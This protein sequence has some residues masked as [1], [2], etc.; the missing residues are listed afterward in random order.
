M[1]EFMFQGQSKVGSVASQPFSDS[2][3]TLTRDVP[4][5]DQPPEENRVQP[6]FNSAWLMRRGLPFVVSGALALLTLWLWQSLVNQDRVRIHRLLEGEMAKVELT[7]QK[8]FSL[9]STALVRMAE[10]R[11]GETELARK[12]WENDATHYLRDFPGHWIIEWIDSAG[13]TRWGKTRDGVSPE[14]LKLAKAALERFKRNM[15]PADE[16]TTGTVVPLQGNGKDFI[17]SVPIEHAGKA[18]GCILGVFHTETL[19]REFIDGLPFNNLGVQFLYQ[20]EAIAT[21]GVPPSQG[22]HTWDVK[23]EVSLNNVSLNAKMYPAARYLANLKSPLPSLA[24]VLGMLMALLVGL[25]IGVAQMARRQQIS[26]HRVNQDLR[27]ENAERTRIQKE[28]LES[29]QRFRF[30]FEESP[31]GM[32]L[33]GQD[34]MVKSAN[35]ALSRLLGYPGSELETLFL[36]DIIDPQDRQRGEEWV[37]RAFKGENVEQGL[38]YRCVTQ[39]GSTV[40]VNLRSSVLTHLEGALPLLLVM[41]EDVTPRKQIEDLQALQTAVL[42]KTIQGR[43]LPEILDALCLQIEQIVGPSVC[44]IMLLDKDGERLN[45]V[46]APSAPESLCGTLNGLVPGE[47]MASCGTA[48]FTGKPVIVTDTGSDPRWEKFRNVAEKFGIKSCWSIPIFSHGHMPLGSFA[49]SHPHPR[50]PTSLDL[51]VLETAS[52]LAGVAIQHQQAAEHLQASEDR[53]RDLFQSAPSAYITTTMEGIILSANTRTSELLGYSQEQ[54]IGSQMMDFYVNGSEGQEKANQVYQFVGTKS[55]MMGQDLKMIG[56]DGSHLWVNLAVQIFYD[57]EGQPIERRE[58]LEDVTGRK[59]AEILLGNQKTILEMI[60]QGKPLTQILTQLCA[61]IESQTPGMWCSV[62][63]LEGQTL[64]SAAAPHLPS[65]FLRKT[66]RVPI[67]P[68]AGS[69][70]TAAYRKERVIVADIETDPL[71]KKGRRLALENGLRACWSTPIKPSDEVLGTFAMY[72]GESRTPTEEETRLIDISTGLAGMAIEQRRAVEALEY[73]KEKYRVLYED[74]PTMYFTVASDGTVLSVNQF[75]ASQLGYTPEELVGETVLKVIYPEDHEKAQAR[76]K[77]IFLHPDEVSHWEFRKIRKDRSLLWVKETARVITRFDGSSVVLIVCED[78]SSQKKVE[79]AL[80]E[81]IELAALDAEISQVVMQREGLPEMLQGCAE[82]LVPSLKAGFGGIWI[83][84]DDDQVLELK[85]S[86]GLVAHPDGPPH[87]VPVGALRL[88]AIA[89][90]RK[91]QVTK[92]IP[93]DPHVLEQEWA[94]QEGLTSFAGYPLIL[95][96]SVIGVLAVYSRQELNVTTLQALG[97]VANRITLGIEKIRAEDAR[98]ESEGRLQAILDNSSA[99]IYLKDLEGRYL[100]INRTYERIFKLD[101]NRVKGKTDK[102]IFPEEI[103]KAF[104]ENDRVALQSGL[105]FEK[106]E[107]APRED[108]L[109][110]Y[111]SN[112]FPLLTADGVPYALCGISTDIT[113]RKQAETAL[114]L[115]EQRLRGL[116][117]ERTKISQDLH[118]HI[119]QSLYAAGLIIAAA[120]QPVKIQDSQGALDYLEQAISQLNVA[121]EEIRIFIEGLPRESVDLGDFST[122]L[123]ALVEALTLPKSTVFA[124]DLDP[125]AVESLNREK[126]LHLLNITRESMS[127]CVRHAQATKGEIRL[128]TLNGAVRFEVKD[129]GIGFEKNGQE[130]MGHGLKN[131][132]ARVNQM[133]GKLVIESVKGRGTRIVV[134][135]PEEKG[136]HEIPR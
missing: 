111:L 128:Q 56:A 71:W 22:A 42:E 35:K 102:D 66:Q 113:K 49:I 124:V 29:E 99:V 134:E 26:L 117:E 78:I 89:Q 79:Q 96:D 98:K 84:N 131:M 129:N 17:L 47:Q 58:M 119:L 3:P 2:S 123:H 46:A 30:S 107:I 16:R 38:E 27:Q 73:S 48:V 83:V 62:H 81:R 82:C 19:L 77:N 54:L 57:A 39:V 9:Q 52:Y 130:T 68:Q 86:A 31:M 112:K 80:Q 7:I 11:A 60:A 8:A 13:V 127:N 10:R 6:T 21:F 70:G 132:H 1:P 36:G 23:S 51:K 75:G 76:V 90:E 53:Y 34:L 109:H 91:P 136:R 43:P 104:I 110:T 100:L 15:S 40:W 28:L 116:L 61:M 106:E 18:G 55:P 125:Q 50:H 95:H 88:G 118:D 87:H 44:S 122:E 108:G 135:L 121:I 67:G 14:K 59:H 69:C 4:G 103:A 37:Q 133:K 105:A 115:S 85:A 32:A 93:E 114:Q 120:K 63:I 101:R 65:P 33:L 45:V 92:N 97:M 12:E 24:F 72:F 74:N 94:K 20:D 25:V 41:L 64:I 126:A 5:G